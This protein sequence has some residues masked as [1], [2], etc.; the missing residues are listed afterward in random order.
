M[1]LGTW[2]SLFIGF[3]EQKRWRRNFLG[4]GSTL[5][6]LDIVAMTLGFMS[7][8]NGRLARFHRARDNGWLR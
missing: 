7:D 1:S 3:D 5:S 8:F 4:V 6:H 2:G